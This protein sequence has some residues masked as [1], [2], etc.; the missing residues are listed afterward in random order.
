MKYAV[1]FFYF[2]ISKANE[3]YPRNSARKKMFFFSLV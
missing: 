1:L 2:P 3:I